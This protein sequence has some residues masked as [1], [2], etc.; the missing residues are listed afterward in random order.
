MARAEA[1][2]LVDQ[3]IHAQ[4]LT[5]AFGLTDRLQRGCPVSMNLARVSLKLAHPLVP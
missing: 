2:T 4:A 5:G 3:I 1:T